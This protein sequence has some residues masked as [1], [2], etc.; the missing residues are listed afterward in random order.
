MCPLCGRIYNSH[1]QYCKL[2]HCIYCGS[3]NISD[4]GKNSRTFKIILCLSFICIVIVFAVAHY[5]GK[6]LN[7]FDA[8]VKIF[9]GAIFYGFFVLWMYR[10]VGVKKYRCNECNK[11]FSEPITGEIRLIDLAKPDTIQGLTVPINFS[12]RIEEI[13]DSPWELYNS[14]R[15]KEACHLFGELAIFYTKIGNLEKACESFYFAGKCSYLSGNYEF[16]ER[17]YCRAVNYGFIIR[18]EYVKK[19]LD[20]LEELYNLIGKKELIKK[21]E[22]VKN[23]FEVNDVKYCPKCGEHLPKE[24]KYCGVCGYK[25]PLE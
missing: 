3:T 23:C 25:L 2:N 19:A 9:I 11:K 10:Y 20:D 14:K 24:A 7:M 8:F 17:E 21:V 4:K 15:Y 6:F 5:S 22:E 13:G 18:S 16:A 12:R 1:V